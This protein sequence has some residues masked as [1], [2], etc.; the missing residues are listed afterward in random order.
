MFSLFF[1]IIP[2]TWKSWKFVKVPCYL[3]LF[4]PYHTKK[5]NNFSENNRSF[6]RFHT[7]GTYKNKLVL[8]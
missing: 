2:F 8:V 4:S 6:A 1:N 3:S 5:L 7:T